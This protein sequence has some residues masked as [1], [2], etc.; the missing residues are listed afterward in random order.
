MPAI[1]LDRLQEIIGERIRVC[2]ST[3]AELT[4]YLANPKKPNIC[5]DEIPRYKD[6]KSG[7]E[8]I[9]GELCGLMREIKFV[10]RQEVVS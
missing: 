8:W 1:Q 7:N 4:E 2:E 9:I 10:A 5:A 3:V 6:R